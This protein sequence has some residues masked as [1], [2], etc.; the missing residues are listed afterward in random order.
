MPDKRV[1]DGNGCL[2]CWQNKMKHG[3]PEAQRWLKKHPEFAAKG[4]SYETLVRGKESE[5][6]PRDTFDKYK[7]YTYLE[8]DC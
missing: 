3:C 1:R 7:K 5:F 4:R 6:R 2:R 8:E